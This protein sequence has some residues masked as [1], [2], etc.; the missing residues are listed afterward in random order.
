VTR[1]YTNYSSPALATALLLV[2]GLLFA[3]SV[4]AQEVEPRRW[5]HLPVGVNF[6]GVGYAYSDVDIFFNP[7]LQLENVNGEIH[8]TVVSYVRGLNVFGKTGRIDFLVPYSVG[9]WDGLQAG[10][11]ASTRRSGFNDPKVRFAVN[12]IGPPAQRGA[13]FRPFNAGTILGVALE[14]FVPIGEYYEDR[15]INLGKNRWTFRPQ[16]GVVH[17]WNKW[18]AELT[19]SVFFYT[20]NDDFFDDTERKQ[21]PLPAL[22][23]HLIYTFRPGLWASLSAAYGAGAES[24]IDGVEVG[25]EIGRYLLAASFGYPIN[26]RQ[27][28]KF[29]YLLGR[30]TEDNGNDADRVLLAYSVMWGGK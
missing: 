10:V 18:A 19:G 3:Q 25:D 11:P 26:R 14:V 30:T 8:T 23:G 12:L 24:T 1:N 5:S 21:D 16:I 27:G 17:S 13:D 4:V 7:A 20:D 2:L 28:I 9:R 15:L 29:T 6:A 22:Q